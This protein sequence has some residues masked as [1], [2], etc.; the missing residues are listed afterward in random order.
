MTKDQEKAEKLFDILKRTNAELKAL[1]A[2]PESSK[3]QDTKEDQTF[4][5]YVKVGFEYDKE[6]NHIKRTSV[7]IA[8]MSNIGVLCAAL[9][10]LDKA[11][12]Y[13]TQTGSDMND[14]MVWLHNL[15]VED[16]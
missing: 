1:D 10:L 6:T 5:H 16:I 3:E 7:R 15:G 9:T 11:K 14:I 4:D 13:L 2:A 12:E 8:N